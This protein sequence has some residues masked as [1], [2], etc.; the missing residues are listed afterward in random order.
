[1]GLVNY[2][3]SEISYSESPNACRVAGPSDS[4]YDTEFEVGYLVPQRLHGDIEPN[5]ELVFTF[6]HIFEEL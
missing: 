3:G 1:M 4:K 6:P 2:A 5:Q